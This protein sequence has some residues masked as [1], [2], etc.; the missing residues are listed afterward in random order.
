MYVD[1]IRAIGVLSMNPFQIIFYVIFTIFIFP[2]SPMFAKQIGKEKTESN[3]NSKTYRVQAGDSWWGIAKKFHLSVSE[4]TSL[5]GR[6]EKEAL[7]QNE[8][9]RISGQSVSKEEFKNFKP[10]ERP[11]YPLPLKEKI[12]HAYSEITHQ[13][14]K[15]IEFAKVNSAWVR[16]TLPGKVIGIDYMDGYENYVILEHENGWFSVYGNL[17][18]V[19]VVEGQTLSAKERIGTLTKNRGLYFQ[20]NQNKN[21]VNPSLFLQDGF[22]LE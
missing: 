1:I 7:F 13:P 12:E 18:R 16:A 19:Q 8:L 17:E 10:K 22:N 6:T 20:V 2:L 11:N 9:L 14:R 3:K 15:G 21:V 5:N 4:L